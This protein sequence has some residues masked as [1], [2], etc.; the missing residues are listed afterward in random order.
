[1]KLNVDYDTFIEEGLRL[2]AEYW[3]GIADN[4]EPYQPFYFTMSPTMIKHLKKKGWCPD[5]VRSTEELQ[6]TQEG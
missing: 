3:R 2:F 6:T 5:N 4:P 1:M